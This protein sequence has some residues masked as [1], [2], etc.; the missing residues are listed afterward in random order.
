MWQQW[1]VV[2]IINT[3]VLGLIT[4]TL[5]NVYCVRKI[6]DQYY[7]KPLSA[8]GTRQLWDPGIV[9]NVFHFGSHDISFLDYHQTADRK[10]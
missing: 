6:L 2:V 4:L 9:A 1:Y 3:A 8:Y 5:V 10:Q 7:Q